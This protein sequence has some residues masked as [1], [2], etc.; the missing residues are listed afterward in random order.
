MFF[1]EIEISHFSC[2]SNN[3]FVGL[4]QAHFPD[5]SGVLMFQDF[6]E[7]KDAVAVN[8]PRREDHRRP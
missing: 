7:K 3:M 2:F 8:E 1:C 4:H 5:L 6:F